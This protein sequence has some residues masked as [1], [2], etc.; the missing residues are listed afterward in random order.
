MFLSYED[1]TVCDLVVAG[2]ENDLYSAEMG[3]LTYQN[4]SPKK[5]VENDHNYN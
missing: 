1:A 5:V 3:L 4:V 2:L